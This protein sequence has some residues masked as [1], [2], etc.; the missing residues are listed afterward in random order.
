M[1]NLTINKNEAEIP[2]SAILKSPN[3]KMEMHFNNIKKWSVNMYDSSFTLHYFD[4]KEVNFPNI[5]AVG[6]GNYADW[7]DFSR[8]F[9]TPASCIGG[10]MF[11]IFNSDNKKFT[12]IPT[13]TIITE[14]SISGHSIKIIYGDEHKNFFYNLEDLTWYKLEKINNLKELYQNSLIGKYFHDIVNAP[15]PLQPPTKKTK[16]KTQHKTIT[17]NKKDSDTAKFSSKMI[18][19]WSIVF[20]LAVLAVIFVFLFLF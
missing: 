14:S 1:K 9:V 5:K 16:K 12:I 19:I 8:Y 11:F 10:N 17:A 18:I 3:E 13:D 15:K 4:G 20:L 2:T 6:Y 7:G